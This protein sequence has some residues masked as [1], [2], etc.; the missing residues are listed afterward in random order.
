MTDIHGF[1]RMQHL[2][3]FGNAVFSRKEPLLQEPLQDRSHRRPMDQLQHEQVRLQQDQTCFILYM[4]QYLYPSAFRQ[5]SI[6]LTPANVVGRQRTG[7]ASNHCY[8]ISYHMLYNNSLT[9]QLNDRLYIIERQ[10]RNITH[11]TAGC[12]R[13]LDGVSPWLT[14]M[15]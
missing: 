5:G 15:L 4:I 1:Q 2:L 6:K 12:D 11:T 10:R 13:N 7:A 14:H 9:W 3:T 8:L